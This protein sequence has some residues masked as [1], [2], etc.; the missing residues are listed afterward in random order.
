M[1]FSHRAPHKPNPRVFGKDHFIPAW[2]IQ[3][4]FYSAEDS[5]PPLL[6]AN[7]NIYPFHLF[8]PNYIFSYFLQ[9]VS[10]LL[11]FLPFTYW[12]GFGNPE[13]QAFGLFP[14]PWE[15]HKMHLVLGKLKIRNLS[16][17]FNYMFFSLFKN[18]FGRHWWLTPVILATQE[19]E[20][21]SIAAQSQPRQIVHKTLSQ[22][23]THHKKGWWSGSR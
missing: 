4:S 6:N 18:Q 17:C 16:W 21:R 5:R 12:E 20:I 10:S 8:D 23:K 3:S 2:F 14:T 13:I 7:T 15:E 9:T 1:Y 11:L 22:K 19:A